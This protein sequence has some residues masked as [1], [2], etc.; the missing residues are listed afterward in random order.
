MSLLGKNAATEHET[1][2]R[3]SAVRVPEARGE[4]REMSFPERLQLPPLLFAAAEF[5]EGVGHHVHL[6]PHVQSNE[7]AWQAAAGRGGAVEHVASE[8]LLV[9][10]RLHRAHS[11]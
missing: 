5:A 3:F 10:L 1:G 8:Q 4:G 6:E 11:P 9:H 2:D 7:P